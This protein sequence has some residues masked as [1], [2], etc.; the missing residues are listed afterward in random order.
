[1]LVWL[2]SLY[3]C[4]RQ[5]LHG[6]KFR[7]IHINLSKKKILLIFWDE[8][9]YFYICILPVICNPEIMFDSK[10]LSAEV[11]SLS[12]WVIHLPTIHFGCTCKGWILP[13]RLLAQRSNNNVVS[14]STTFPGNFV[15]WG[16]RKTL[17]FLCLSTSSAFQ[18]PF[19]ISVLLDFFFYFFPPPYFCLYHK[20]YCNHRLSPSSKMQILVD[21]IIW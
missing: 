20:Q 18:Q 5:F 3:K 6:L 11:S 19:Y 8:P 9:V 12:S 1:M 4:V 7:T 10:Y 21:N 14:Q 2:C 17:A 16:S 15:A 13:L